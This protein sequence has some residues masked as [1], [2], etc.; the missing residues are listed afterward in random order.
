MDGPSGRRPERVAAGS[1]SGPRRWV[2]MAGPTGAGLGRDA[3]DWTSAHGPIDTP[4][5]RPGAS[6]VSHRPATRAMTR[7]AG[8]S[9][10]TGLPGRRS[11]GP[12][13]EVQSTPRPSGP[14]PRATATARQP[15]AIDG[16]AGSLRWSGLL[17]RRSI[18][19]RGEV[20][21]TATRRRGPPRTHPASRTGRGG[22]V[23][24]GVRN[25][26]RGSLP[27]E[28]QSRLRL[29]RFSGRRGHPAQRRFESQHFFLILIFF[30]DFAT[31]RGA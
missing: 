11:I 22:V 25:G 10:W 9:R 20:Q 4:A 27:G 23:G 30:L 18:G 6:D 8:S 5:K 29:L 19:P 2:H 31:S 24:S 15:G 1:S 3:G 26:A 17:G 13:G 14:G 16:S 28:R 7:S 21:S 12:D